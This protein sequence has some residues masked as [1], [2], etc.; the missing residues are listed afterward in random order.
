M[1][2]GR[3]KFEDKEIANNNDK[4]KIGGGGSDVAC[5]GWREYFEWQ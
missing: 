5:V 3:T 1:R 2:R 4:K